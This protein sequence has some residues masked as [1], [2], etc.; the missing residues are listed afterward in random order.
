MKIGG[1]MTEAS[2]NGAPSFRTAILKMALQKLEQRK[3]DFP[4]RRHLRFKHE[5]EWQAHSI[6]A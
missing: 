5:R 3:R 6:L 4:K 1:S 2:S